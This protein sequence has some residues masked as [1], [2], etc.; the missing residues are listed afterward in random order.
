MLI[1]HSKNFSCLPTPDII[2][3]SDKETLHTIKQ[4]PPQCFSVH[5]KLKDDTTDFHRIFTNK[6]T[7]EDLGVM[8]KDYVE[9]G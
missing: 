4:S 8:H 2:G 5:E 1:S 6:Q 3:K 9:I 7:E